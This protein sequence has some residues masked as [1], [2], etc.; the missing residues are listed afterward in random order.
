MA[1]LLRQV[2][3]RR[4]EVVGR[5]AGVPAAGW[6]GALPRAEML[7]RRAD[8]LKARHPAGRPAHPVPGA[9]AT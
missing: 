2:W 7:D 4:T 6:V 3:V 8:H 1:H 5:A 9:L